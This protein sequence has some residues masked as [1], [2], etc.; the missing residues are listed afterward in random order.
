[1]GETR[2]EPGRVRKRPAA[3]I[4]AG[5]SGGSVIKL[6]RSSFKFSEQPVECAL[7]C[8]DVSCGDA[9]RLRCSHGW[10]CKK[11]MEMYAS[12]RLNEGAVDVAC[13]DCREPMPDQ[14]LKKV[15]P[16][17]MISRFHERSISRAVASSANLYPCPTPNCGMCYEVDEGDDYHLRRCSKCAKGCCLHCGVQPY[18]HGRSCKKF[19]A[20]LAREKKKS[21]SSEVSLWRWMRRTGTVQCPQ[22]KAGV[23]KEDLASQQTQRKECH[24]MLCRGCNTKFCFKCLAILTDSYT[25]GCSIDAHRFVN[26]FTGKSVQHLRTSARHR[27]QGA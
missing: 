2:G 17:N 8:M 15:L 19:A 3:A 4:S 14:D 11:C 7:C 13:P 24:K 6:Q 25:C 12:A 9:V 22:C 10:Y 23:S 1:M 21:N 20:D 18:H 26:P 5:K 16:R 27:A